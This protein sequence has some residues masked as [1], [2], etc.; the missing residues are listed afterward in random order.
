MGMHV[1]GREHVAT[2]FTNDVLLFRIQLAVD[3]CKVWLG[4]PFHNGLP[5]CL[6]MVL[7]SLAME[8]CAKVLLCSG[9]LIIQTLFTWISVI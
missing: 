2:L 1:R 5:C 9:I 3:W 6:G 4:A 8:S 7:P